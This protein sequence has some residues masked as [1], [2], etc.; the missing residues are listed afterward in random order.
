MFDACR[1]ADSNQMAKFD[2]FID[3]KY[4]IEYDGKQHF[5]EGGWGNYETIKLHDEHKNQWCQTNNIPLIRIPYTQYDHLI[6]D[7][8]MLE[9]TNYR[10]V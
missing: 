4:L 7:D 8:I 1:F 3:N 5:G 6:L 9:K 2:F 10:V